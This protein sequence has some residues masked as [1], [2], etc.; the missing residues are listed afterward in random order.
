MVKKQQ[1]MK[2]N[3]PNLN[4]YKIIKNSV[5]MD[6]SE[7]LN[8]STPEDNNKEYQEMHNEINLHVQE[9]D[10]NTDNTENMDSE[11]IEDLKSSIMNSHTDV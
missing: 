9:D 10:D 2:K 7:C 6:E 4:E 11:N 3:S 1:T 8:K 5:E